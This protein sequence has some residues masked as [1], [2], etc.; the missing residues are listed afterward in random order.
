MKY[1]RD[2]TGSISTP[3]GFRSHFHL[4]LFG[5][6]TSNA[7][8]REL[9]A[10]ASDRAQLLRAMRVTG[11]DRAMYAASSI[12]RVIVVVGR[13]ARTRHFLPP[14]PALNLK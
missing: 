11:L 7:Q 9:I 3:S 14:P 12:A 8:F 4:V 13:L 5:C 1:L 10:S 2:L 6:T